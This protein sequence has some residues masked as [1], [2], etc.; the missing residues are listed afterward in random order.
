M[1]IVG[2]LP[3]YYIKIFSLKIETLARPLLGPHLKSGEMGQF[4]HE[5]Y[6]IFQGS[7]HTNVILSH[8]LT[9]SVCLDG[10]AAA[11]WL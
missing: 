9:F 6:N 3:P 11:L 4:M 1:Y 10:I 8:K 7:S 5:K 2:P